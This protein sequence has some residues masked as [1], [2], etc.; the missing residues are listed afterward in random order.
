[1]EALKPYIPALLAV[2]F[3]LFFLTF[4]RLAVLLVV[5]IFMIFAIAYAAIVYRFLKL[6]KEMRSAAS[7]PQDDAFKDFGGEPTFKNV[8]IFMTQRGKWWISE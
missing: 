8:T 2:F 5:S 6:R 7:Q 1:M 3:A 4:P